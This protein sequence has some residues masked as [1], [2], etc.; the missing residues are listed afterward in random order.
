MTHTHTLS[1]VTKVTN[2]VHL[3]D[4]LTLKAAEMDTT[5]YQQQAT[6][7]LAGYANL[8]QFTVLDVT[9]LGPARGKVSF[10]IDKSMCFLVCGVCV[11]IC[12]CVRVIFQVFFRV[13]FSP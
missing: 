12:V 5:K 4:P 11:Y 9:M 1:Q 3:L 2:L 6:Q 10:E 7:I 8:I 13:V